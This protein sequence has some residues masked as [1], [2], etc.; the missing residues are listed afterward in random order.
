MD[1]SHCRPFRQPCLFF[2]MEIERAAQSRNRLLNRV[3]AS[4]VYRTVC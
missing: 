4:S 2:L 3:V 1:L